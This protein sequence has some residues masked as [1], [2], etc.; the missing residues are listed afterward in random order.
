M[1]FF[2]FF[3]SLLFSSFNLEKGLNGRK[4]KRFLDS[5][6]VKLNFLSSAKLLFSFCWLI[7]RVF[8]GFRARQL[9]G[10]VFRIF[11]GKKFKR[12]FNLYLLQVGLIEIVSIIIINL[13][14]NFI[15]FKIRNLF[16]CGSSFFLFFFRIKFNL[17]IK[18]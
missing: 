13:E 8:M 2:L 18:Y 10:I 14:S 16:I 7:E 15:S 1:N 9:L 17:G 6:S 12:N 11:E 3:F 4:K 5:S